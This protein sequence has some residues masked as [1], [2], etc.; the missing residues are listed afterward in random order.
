M[1]SPLPSMAD[2]GL[3][4]AQTVAVLMVVFQLRTL[5]SQ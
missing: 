5:A 3:C 1:N 2:C 4:F